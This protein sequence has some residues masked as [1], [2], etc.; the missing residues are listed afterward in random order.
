MTRIEVPVRSVMV[1]PGPGP[2]PSHTPGHSFMDSTTF[3]SLPSSSSLPFPS[4]ESVIHNGVG[5]GVGMG[6][7]GLLVVDRA[8]KACYVNPLH[9]HTPTVTNTA[10]AAMTTGAV[11]STL[12]D[13]VPL[14]RGSFVVLH[15]GPFSSMSLADQSANHDGNGNG[16]GG[17][18]LFGTISSLGERGQGQG[19]GGQGKSLS[20]QFGRAVMFHGSPSVVSRE[21]KDQASKTAGAM[22]KSSGG[23]GGFSFWGS[24]GGSGS[25][26]L[27]TA[28]SKHPQLMV[29]PSPQH[30][31]FSASSSPVSPVVHVSLNTGMGLVRQVVHDT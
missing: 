30:S 28:D 7:V 22:G 5:M 29:P 3:P 2:S 1:V 15:E 13:D 9:I 31:S 8:G 20:L 12:D 16:G 23:L 10:A 24:G 4:G 11:T 14:T 26:K 27:T 18:D 17:D 25:S 21:K 19:Q 6:G